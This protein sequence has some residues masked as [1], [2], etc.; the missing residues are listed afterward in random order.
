MI[1]IQQLTKKYGEQ[2]VLKALTYQF[3]TKGLVCLF[4]PSGCGKSTLLNLMAGFDSDYEG[5]IQVGEV[6]LQAMSFDE[7]CAYRRNHVGFIFQNYHLISGCSVLENMLLASEDETKAIELLRSLSIYEKIHEKVE[8]LSGGQKQRVAIARALMKNPQIIFAD[9]PTGALDR[10]SSKET[11]ELL[12]QLAQ[13]RLVIVV[14]HDHHNCDYADEVLKFI[15]GQIVSNQDIHHPHSETLW[16]APRQPRSLVSQAKLNFK[17]HFKRYLG[18][19]LAI[20]LG[21]VAFMLSLSSSNIMQQSILDFQSKNTAFNNGYIREN[22]SETLFQQ[23][24]GDERIENVYQQFVLNDLELSNELHSET[25]AEKYPMPK[26]TESLSYGT[27]PKV[28]QNEIALTPSL[29]KK[30]ASDIKDLIGQNVTLK[31]EDASLELKVSGIYNAAYDDFFISSDLERNIMEKMSGTPYSLSYDVGL[32]D[33]IVAVSSE[34]KAQGIDSKNAALEVET[35]ITTFTNLQRLFLILSILIFV[36]GYFLSVSL[37]W[38]LQASRF[39]EVGLLS[40]L[41][42]E[43]R[44]IS[45]MIQQ[46]NSYLTCLA[47]LS[48][49]GLILVAI[50]VNSIFD[51]Q[52]AL[53][54]GDMG[55]CIAVTWLLVYGTGLLLNRKLIQVEPAKALRM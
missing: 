31:I 14:T 51:F 55:Q 38:K 27:L 12:K 26:T 11:M 36:I 24:S 3:P 33:D 23:L 53:S 48:S 30:F 46:E 43:K 41:G 32:F 22:L 40:A 1:N 54:V 4:G 5:S 7:L 45:K 21:I 52:L 37:L 17:H 49:G 15:D 20:S 47:T 8:H 6:A 42:Y 28:N 13:D 29:A 44:A 39:S 18:V 35:L 50:V 19:S 2:T 25:M 10:H 16:D 9:E 34:L